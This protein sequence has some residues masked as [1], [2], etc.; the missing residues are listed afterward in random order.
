VGESTQDPEMYYTNNVAGSLNLIKA[1]AYH[2]VGSFVFSS[3]CSVYGNPLQIPITEEETI[4]PINPYANTK[5][6]IETILKDFDMAYG[7]KYAALRYFNAAGA[8]SSGTIGE[9]HIPEPHLIPNVLLNAL[10]QIDKISVFGNDYPTPD[11]TCIRDYIHVDD[12]AEAHLKALHFLVEGRKSDFFNLGTGVGNSVLEIIQKASEITGRQINFE[13]APRRAG[14]P[15]VLIAD[16]RK[17]AEI[18][19]WSPARTIDDIIESA[20]RWHQNPKY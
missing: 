6:I 1:T 3:T 5:F 19:N 2:D 15:A 12:L 8:H 11:G 18:L 16:S 13:I 9:S 14:D 20:W 7:L 10:G 17:A 4:K